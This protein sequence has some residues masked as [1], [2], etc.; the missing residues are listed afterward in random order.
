MRGFRSRDNVFVRGASLPGGASEVC[1]RCTGLGPFSASHGHGLAWPVGA[2][3]SGFR[4]LTPTIPPDRARLL[5]RRCMAKRATSMVGTRIAPRLTICH[6][7]KRTTPPRRPGAG[8][9]RRRRA[10]C[11]AA[12]QQ[13][14]SIQVADTGLVTLDATANKERADG[15]E[16][17]EPERWEPGTWSLQYQRRVE[18]E[19]ERQ[20]VDDLTLEV[21]TRV[22]VARVLT[23]RTKIH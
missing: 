10:A 7:D 13:A 22:A 21:P 20:E 11:E 1:Y 17:G 12:L 5:W 6:S 8:H 9:A 15:D 2:S 14:C 16:Q 4:G 19:I 23:E 3:A 18:D